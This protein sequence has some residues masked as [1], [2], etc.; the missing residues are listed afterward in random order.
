MIL[1]CLILFAK[2]KNIIFSFFVSSFLPFLWC[3][4]L[5]LYQQSH[6]E[7]MLKSTNQIDYEE[8]NKPENDASKKVNID[9]DAPIFTT[10]KKTILELFFSI[11]FQCFYQIISF[12][13]NLFFSFPS[14]Y[15]LSNSTM[16]IMNQKKK[17]IYVPPKFTRIFEMVIESFLFILFFS[18]FFPF[19]FVLFSISNN[20]K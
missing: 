7:R 17:A 1:F 10:P 3:S 13:P 6:L 14:T 20:L 18:L 4:H 12:F 9:N 5:S 19:S 8:S 16:T 2:K 15:F 11:E